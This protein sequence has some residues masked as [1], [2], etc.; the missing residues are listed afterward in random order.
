MENYGEN[1][2][3]IIRYIKVSVLLV[4]SI[5][6]K[7]EST[8]ISFLNELLFYELESYLECGNFSELSVVSFVFLLNYTVLCL[9]A[10]GWQVHHVPDAVL[11]NW[12]YTTT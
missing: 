7:F 4:K 2:I 1:T 12:C 6:L 8:V 3:K 11:N 10:G 9:Y 5:S